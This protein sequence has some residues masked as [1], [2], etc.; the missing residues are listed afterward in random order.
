MHESFFGMHLQP[1]AVKL[2]QIQLYYF[3]HDHPRY[4]TQKHLAGE[5][6]VILYN[7]YIRKLKMIVTRESICKE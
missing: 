5:V 3:Y 6:P 1:I 4:I 7:I 2:H